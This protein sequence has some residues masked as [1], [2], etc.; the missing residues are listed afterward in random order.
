MV[1]TFARHVLCRAILV[2]LAVALTAVERPAL[3]AD[4]PIKKTLS[5]KLRGRLPH[6]YAAV[7]HDEQREKIYQIQEEYRPKIEALETQLKTLKKERDA[8]VAAV[9]TAEQRKQVEE[10]AAKAK[11][12]RAK[13]AENA[14]ATPPAKQKPSK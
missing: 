7:V 11:A 10:A 5:Q 4:A 1:R 12:N 9:L 14:P 3:A 2:S 13:P 6:Y 8:K